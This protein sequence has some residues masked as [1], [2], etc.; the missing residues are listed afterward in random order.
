MGPRKWLIAIA[1]VAGAALICYVLLLLAGVLQY[2]GGSG[3]DSDL[4]ASSSSSSAPA[5]TMSS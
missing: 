1:A 5:P 2:K 3:I 4:P